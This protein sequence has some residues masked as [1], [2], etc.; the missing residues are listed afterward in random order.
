MG[1]WVLT[2]L[3]FLFG[4]TPYFLTTPKLSPRMNHSIVIAGAATTISDCQA[5]IVVP[6]IAIKEAGYIK[7][8]TN[9][10]SGHAKHEFH[11]LAQ[12]SYFQFQD[13]ELEVCEINAPLTISC[14]T[15]RTELSG[16]LLLYRDGAGELHVLAHPLQNRKKLLEAAYRYCT[17]WVRLDI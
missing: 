3:P 15:E 5:V 11:T 12:M 1:S 10:D 8:F 2:Q 16:G 4:I 13:D 6:E 9:K 17:R 14:G 7:T